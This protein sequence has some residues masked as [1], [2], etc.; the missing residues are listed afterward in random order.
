MVGDSVQWGKERTML[1]TYLAILD[2]GVPEPGLAHRLR[3]HLRRFFGLADDRPATGLDVEPF[4][5]PDTPTEP[6]LRLVLATPERST[7]AQALR[8]RRHPQLLRR[9]ASD[10]ST[11]Q[12]EARLE[13]VRA[14]Y[15]ARAG[16]L[17]VAEDHFT[18]AA[19]CPEID[20]SAI[21]GFWQLG[22]SAMMTAVEAYE[23]TGRIRDASALN[24][25]I[26]TMYR[27]RALSSVPANVTSLPERAAKIS[28]TP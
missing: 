5:T 11:D 3:E 12:R 28:S 7:L 18:Q 22:R 14:L 20:L 6:I 27:P 24:A 13:A 15:A 21:P 4:T 8:W 16:A 10:L 17:E 2:A 19:L 26:R 9:P 25:R 23:R 1:M